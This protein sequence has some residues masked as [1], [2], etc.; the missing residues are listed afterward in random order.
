MN[1]KKHILGLSDSEFMAFL[2][3]ERD[4]ENN[5]SN[6]QGWNN[7]ALAGAIIT[8]ICSAYAILKNNPSLGVINVSYYVGCLVTFFLAYHSWASLF[9]RERAVDL[10]KV[11]MIEEI[12]PYIKIFFIFF[13]G[14]F[15]SLLTA[16][17]D[18]CN[19]IFW[20]WI[21]VLFVYLIVIFLDLSK[22]DKI[23]P[24]Y[25]GEMILPWYS[26]CIVFD[27][28]IGGVFSII[29]MKS[30][31]LAGKNILSPEFEF[32]A[33]IAIILVLIYILLK[34]NFGNMVVRRFDLII[35]RYLYAG[36]TKEDTFR[37]IMKN[38][39][40]YSAVDA[41]YNELQ[42]VEKEVERCK[43]TESELSAIKQYVDHGKCEL[44][45]L[46]DYQRRIDQ[47]LMNLDNALTKSKTLVDRVEEII[48]VSP[49]FIN[50][51]EI[52]YIIS[53]NQQ[54][55]EKVNSVIISAREVL[56]ALSEAEIKILTETNAALNRVLREKQQ[57]I[58]EFQS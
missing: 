54:C 56:S 39:M 11:R 21:T 45:L 40:G 24:S 13:C 53:R 15:L 38:R 5:L 44:T 48:K 22:K 28:F 4:R 10:S 58:D 7:W 19:V 57:E 47:I 25:Y 36:A 27:A 26:V 55:F 14:V 43:K 17:Y 12:V 23:V 30:Y 35:D 18:S 42:S 31:N 49:S 33:C 20:L 16:I 1:D 2:F 3:S 52:Q 41:C 9:K 51:S 29:M 32:A 34:L 46:Q 50:T 8:A 6:F 37:E